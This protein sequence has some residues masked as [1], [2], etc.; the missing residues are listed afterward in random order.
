M[1]RNK[2]YSRIG[3]S[4]K[5]SLVTFI[6][7]VVILGTML[8]LISDRL[9]K[10]FH[11][12]QIQGFTNQVDAIKGLVVFQTNLVQ[13]MLTAHILNPVYAESLYT[14]DLSEVQKV[15]KILHSNLQILDATLLVDTSGVIVSAAAE[16]H[17]GRSIRDTVIWKAIQEGQAY[18]VDYTLTESPFS[19]QPVIYHAAR[20]M[21]EREE[22]GFLVT[23]MEMRIFSAIYISPMKFGETGYPFV[24]SE[25]GLII[26]HPDSNMIGQDISGE[27]FF[28]QIGK[29]MEEQKWGNNAIHYSMNG[30]KRVL[31]YT[32]VLSSIPW[33]TA[34]SMT[35]EEI[36]APIVAVIR[37]VILIGVAAALVMITVLILFLR[38]FLIRRIHTLAET[39]QIAATGDLSLHVREKGSDEF[40]DINRRFNRLMDSLVGLISQVRERMEKL[41]EGGQD[42]SSNVQQTAAAINQIN[43]NIE[44]TRG[45]ISNQSVNISETS[46]T[47]EQMTKNVESLS[48]TIEHQSD[49]VTQS[50]TAVEEMVQSIREISTTTGKAA[51]EVKGL[52]GASETGK[53][54]MDKM[55]GLIKEISGMSTALSEANT[56]IAKIASQT[57]LL[58]MNAAIE[59]AHAGDAGAGFSV[60][61]EEIRKLAENASQQSKEVKG[62]LAEV[63]KAV[64]EVVEISA[65]TDDAFN[66][67]I[68][69]IDGV[70]R[71]FEE[72]RS[73]MEEQSSGS[74]QLLSILTGMTQITETVRSGSEEMN[75]GNAQILEVVKN[76]NAISQEVKNA[77]EE[78][79]RGTGEINNA[80]KNIVELSD[81]N[82]ESIR[83]VKQE[84]EKFRLTAEEADRVR[85]RQ[86][87]EQAGEITSGGSAADS[88]AGEKAEEHSEEPAEE[89]AGTTVLKEIDDADRDEAAKAAAEESTPRVSNEPAGPGAEAEIEAEPEGTLEPLPEPGEEE[90]GVREA[91]PKEE[92]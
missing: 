90:S 22:V 37:M 84:T 28:Q 34:V 29:E 8:L 49:S 86:I 91:F 41:D 71:V 12:V 45:Q 36:M 66:R 11:E 38:S 55:V 53:T 40:S 89:P 2:G 14:G 31:V 83:L 57:S 35:E 7:L 64:A 3:I 24:F 50:S 23:A 15:I 52:K 67:I 30:E 68:G 79:A 16:K 63:E 85:E 75:L 82:T 92:K 54:Q 76:L 21:R 10:D 32:P 25:N 6:L 42:L 69:S 27:D 74:E 17:I 9:K 65:D 81:E 77:I 47:V 18:P 1:K 51:E 72:I 70:Q 33:Y 73:A 87:E 43:A 39:L 44:S 56:V 19:G 62:R 20:I 4:V 78:I 61:A 60:V 46:A 13:R 59:A 58:S 5:V 88:Q 80:V 26:A 48:K